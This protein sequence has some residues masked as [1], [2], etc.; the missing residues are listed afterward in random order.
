MSFY[1]LAEWILDQDRF[2]ALILILC[3]VALIRPDVKSLAILFWVLG[4]FSTQ[5]PLAFLNYEIEY[6]SQLVMQGLVSFCLIVFFLTVQ[7]SKFL[8]MSACA[9]LTMI[10]INA[11]WVSLVE[12]AMILE[13]HPYYQWLAF[14]I[15]NYISFIGVCL[16]KWGDKKRDKRPIESDIRPPRIMDHVYNRDGIM[17]K[18]TQELAQWKD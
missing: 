12:Y 4:Y 1:Q 17:G 15:L 3:A 8:M 13:W 16:N 5:L 14:A 11:V 10:L 2:S 9:E 7:P 6:S 18:T